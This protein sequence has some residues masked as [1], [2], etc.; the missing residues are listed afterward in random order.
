M[1][2][3]VAARVNK[4][5]LANNANSLGVLICQSCVLKSERKKSTKHEQGN[6]SCDYVGYQCA[7]VSP[8]I[9]VLRAINVNMTY[10]TCSQKGRQF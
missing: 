8:E 9:L 6:L 5:L 1:N 4:I 10:L 7:H 2:A 3:S